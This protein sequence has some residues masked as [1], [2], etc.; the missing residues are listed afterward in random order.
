MKKIILVSLA[1]LALGFILYTG[2]WY[3]IVRACP[4]WWAFFLAR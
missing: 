3:F 4:T 1:A 2:Y